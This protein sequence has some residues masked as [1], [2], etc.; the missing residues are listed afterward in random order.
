MN[1]HL[2]L[3]CVLSGLCYSV[4]GE[5]GEEGRGGERRGEE[6]RGEERRGEERRGEE[7]R[8]EERRRAGKGVLNDAIPIFLLCKMHVNVFLLDP[9]TR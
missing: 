1:V 7:R 8:G 2:V 4:E 6:R 3:V 9:E 5:R